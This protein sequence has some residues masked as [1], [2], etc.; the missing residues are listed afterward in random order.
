MRKV[1]FFLLSSLFVLQVQADDLNTVRDLLNSDNIQAKVKDNVKERLWDSLNTG[2]DGNLLG[3]D[4]AYTLQVFDKNQKFNLSYSL[5]TSV[6]PATSMDDYHTVW[7]YGLT[8]SA[9]TDT[10]DES[11]SFPTL[12]GLQRA[13]QLG[14]KFNYSR[15]PANKDAFMKMGETVKKWRGVIANQIRQD[16]YPSEKCE[17][18]AHRLSDRRRSLCA[19]GPRDE[20]RCSWRV[21]L[22]IR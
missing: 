18:S 21:V 1:T 12:D 15:I 20:L 2:P 11:S 22:R 19:S 6:K 8:F 3:D 17:Q 13:A 16:V 7:S 5:G 4:N 9:P 14:L 10:E